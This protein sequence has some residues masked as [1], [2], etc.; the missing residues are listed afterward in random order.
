MASRP[1]Q[2]IRSIDEETCRRLAAVGITTVRDLLVT[3]PLRLMMA[4]NLSLDQV[5]DLLLLTSDAVKPDSISVLSLLRQRASR[6]RFLKTG[7]AALDTAL[8][9]G[10]LLGIR[11]PCHSTF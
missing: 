3:S 7:V 1:L 5:E 4:A 8:H 10:L 9:G 6:R 2:R 11:I